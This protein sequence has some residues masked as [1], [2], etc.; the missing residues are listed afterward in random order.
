MVAITRPVVPSVLVNSA[1]AAGAEV[2]G[3]DTLSTFGDA[4]SVATISVPTV[5]AVPSAMPA[6]S[7]TVNCN[8][9]SL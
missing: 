4:S 8:C 9:W 2:H 7:L 6:G 1:A 3:E 5:R